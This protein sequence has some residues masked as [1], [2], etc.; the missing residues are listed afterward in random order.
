MNI[1]SDELLAHPLLAKVQADIAETRQAQAAQR[2]AAEM[3]GQQ[4]RAKQGQELAEQYR[5]AVQEYEQLR[6]QTHAAV[7]RI[8]A[9]ASAY[10]ALTKNPPQG[11]VHQHFAGIHL[12]T[13]IP[14]ASP[15]AMPSMGTTTEDALAAW[16]ASMGKGWV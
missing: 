8:W 16:T 4:A 14:N 3:D 2:I 6:A 11:F 13:L 15:W 10:S 12:P 7:G 5:R 9:A 1:S